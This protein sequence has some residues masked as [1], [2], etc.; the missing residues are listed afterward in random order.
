MKSW[1]SSHLKNTQLLYI[2]ND[3]NKDT[4]DAIKDLEWFYEI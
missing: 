3:I 1:G 4:F 2:S